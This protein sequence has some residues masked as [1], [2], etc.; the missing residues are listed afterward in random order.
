LTGIQIG[1][2]CLFDHVFV[3]LAPVSGVEHLHQYPG[4]GVELVLVT[5]AI[6]GHMLTKSVHSPSIKGDF[7]LWKILLDQR[8]V[9]VNNS[10]IRGLNSSGIASYGSPPSTWSVVSPGA[11]F[12]V[13]VDTVVI[14]CLAFS[15]HSILF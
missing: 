2:Y 13:L 1:N 6:E 12:T 4:P 3:N 9:L 15:F 7:K 8:R 10:S 11:I 5:A 14:F